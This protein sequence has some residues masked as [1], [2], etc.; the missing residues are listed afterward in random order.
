MRLGICAFPMTRSLETGRGLEKVLV[1]LCAELERAGRAFSFYDLG[2]MKTEAE[3]ILKA[4][5]FLR[6]LRRARDDVYLAIYPVAGIFPIL[7]KKRPVITAVFDMIPYFV[8][9]YD[10]FIKFAIKR[11]CI[12]FACR[13]S[14]YLIVDFAS[15]KDKIIQLFGIPEERIALLSH[16]SHGVNHRLYYPEP[17]CK[18]PYS[19]SFLGEAKRSKG[20]DSVIKAF[21]LIHQRLPEATLTLAS[22]GSELEEMRELARETLPPNTYRFAGFIPEDKMREFYNTAD[23]FMFPSRYG[24]GLSSLE[25]MACGTPA[26]VGKGQDTRDFI[27][28]PDVMVDPDNEEEIAQKALA[29][30]NDRHLYQQKVAQG[31]VL[32]GA[33][34]W[35]NMANKYYDLCRKVY[36]ET[37]AGSDAAAVAAS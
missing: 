36:E 26:I 11:W 20:M 29:L 2:Y 27:D 14:D 6:K 18:K 23:L 32:A 15:N 21:R 22:H 30:F 19:I 7:L 33:Y 37:V 35:E 4:L 28:D 25:A 34:S 12:R 9:G 5:P 16:L 1:E 8:S 13:N 17:G 3:A 24:M 10:S 31:L